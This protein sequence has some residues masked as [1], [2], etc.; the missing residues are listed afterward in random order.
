MKISVADE[1]EL[2]SLEKLSDAELVSLVRDAFK[3]RRAKDAAGSGLGARELEEID[4]PKAQDDP[5]PTPGTPRPDRNG[6]SVA[7]L[8][9][10]IPGYN[11]LLHRN[12]DTREVDESGI[13]RSGTGAGQERARDN[14]SLANVIPGYYRLL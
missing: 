9:A 3:T 10:I 13:V 8:D 12:R 14:G 1:A 6:A 11:R 2:G 5:P 7:A 4:Q